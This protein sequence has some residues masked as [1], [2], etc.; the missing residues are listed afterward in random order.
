MS[1]KI[2]VQALRLIDGK[3]IEMHG[4]ERGSKFA[5]RSLARLFGQG[6]SLAAIYV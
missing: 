6:G 5:V 1:G 2:L 4:G 3:V